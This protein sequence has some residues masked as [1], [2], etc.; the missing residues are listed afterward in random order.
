M[1]SSPLDV[2]Q[3]LGERLRHH[4]FAII[5]IILIITAVALAAYYWLRP[6]STLSPAIEFVGSSAETWYVLDGDQLLPAPTP[7]GADTIIGK[8]GERASAALVLPP[9]QV[10]KKGE[11]PPIGQPQPSWTIMFTDKDGATRSLGYGRPLGFL[12]DGSLLALTPLGVSRVMTD[13]TAFQLVSTGGTVTPMGAAS[14]DLS[15][16][17][18]ENQVTHEVVAYKLDVTTLSTSYVGAITLS[19]PQVPIPEPTVSTTTPG[20]ATSTIRTVV[21]TP[22][23]K[24]ILPASIALMKD[25]F[26]VQDSSGIFHAYALSDKGLG[27]AVT[28]RAAAQ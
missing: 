10:L 4:A 14:A 13:G 22:S 18:F 23:L 3:S 6:L 21:L 24:P 20:M 15:T 11:V 12:P 19:Q 9:Q 16:I 2:P 28:L 1:D 7:A 5:G 17:V 25:R 26:I 8:N 27:E